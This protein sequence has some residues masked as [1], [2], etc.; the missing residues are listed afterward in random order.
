VE[1]HAVLTQDQ[2][3]G[4]LELADDA[5]QIYRAPGQALLEDDSRARFQR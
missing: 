1:V 3:T 5:S 2:F 4:V